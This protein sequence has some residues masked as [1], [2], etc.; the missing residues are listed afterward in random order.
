MAEIKEIPLTYVVPEEDYEEIVR[1]GLSDGKTLISFLHDP[2]LDDVNPD[3]GPWGIIIADLIR[4]LES[5]FQ[6]PTVIR[7]RILRVLAEELQEP[8]SAIA[9]SYQER[10][11]Q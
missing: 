8:T 11:I 10:T 7:K 2:L 6:N 4:H 5:T 1:I 9:G 3:P